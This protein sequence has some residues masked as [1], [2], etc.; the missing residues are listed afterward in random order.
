MIAVDT[1]I[2]VYAHRED[3]D[4]HKEAL[5]ALLLL[6]GGSRLWGIP[7]PCVHEFVSIVTHPSIYSPPTFYNYVLCNYKLSHL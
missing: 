5:N 6:A 3:S 2:L 4:F 1:N 7:W